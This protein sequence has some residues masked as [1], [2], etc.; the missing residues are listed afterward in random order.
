[1]YLTFKILV[2]L[3]GKVSLMKFL[4]ENISMLVMNIIKKFLY[5][6]PV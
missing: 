1:M 5:Q 6:K 2:A 4:L 3:V